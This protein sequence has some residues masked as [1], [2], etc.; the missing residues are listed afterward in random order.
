MPRCVSCSLDLESIGPCGSIKDNEVSDTLTTGILLFPAAGFSAGDAQ[1]ITVEGNTVTRASLAE[2]LPHAGGIGM[3]GGPTG[4]LRNVLI[5]NNKVSD[6]YSTGFGQIRLKHCDSG[7]S[8]GENISILD[9]TLVGSVTGLALD[10]AAYTNVYQ[11]GNV[12]NQ[13]AIPASGSDGSPTG[14]SYGGVEPGAF[15][16]LTV[17]TTSAGF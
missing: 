8:P 10:V 12:Y 17:S 11:A 9:N 7:C 13:S 14:S 2:R 1:G 6:T 4:A 5:R 16:S 15:G 3:M